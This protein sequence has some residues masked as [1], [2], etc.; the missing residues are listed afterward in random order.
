MYC[1]QDDMISRFGE[2]ELIQLTDRAALGVI[3]GTVLDRA[4]ADAAA[5]IDG[6]LAGRYALPL[7]ETPQALTLVACDIA[8]YRLYDDSVIDIVKERYEQ[9]VA[10]LRSLARGEIS[11]VQQTGAV[12]ESA[13]MAEFDGGRS[14]FDGGGF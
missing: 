2:E 14:V 8:R 3:D 6:Y 10:Y 5:E 9:A 13:G 12:A 1:T 4:M 7:A 11:L